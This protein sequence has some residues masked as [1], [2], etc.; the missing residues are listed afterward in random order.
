MAPATSAMNTSST[1]MK[2][3][4]EEA[5]C[6]TSEKQPRTVRREQTE[7]YQQQH[8]LTLSD[9]AAA[10]QEADDDQQHSH[11]DQ[12]VAHV[13]HLVQPCWSVLQFPQEAE[14]GAAVHLHPDPYAQDGGPRQLRGRDTL[15]YPARAFIV[16]HCFLPAESLWT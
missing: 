16:K 11:C 15:F 1:M 10:A 9:G 14:D 5:A 2:N 3:W 4:E 12:Q 7:T 8:A 6:Y 13:E